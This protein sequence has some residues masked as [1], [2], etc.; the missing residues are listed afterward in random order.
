[1][2]NIYSNYAGY[3]YA[4][5]QNAYGYPQPQPVNNAPVQPQPSAQ[6]A[7]TGSNGLP[8]V[9]GIEGAYAFPMPAGV[10]QIILWDDTV[11][12]FYIKGYDNMGKPKVLAWNDFHPHVEEQKPSP[13]PAAPQPI[14]VSKFVTKDDL[15]EALSQLSIGESGRIVRVNE[16]DA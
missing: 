6:Q 7:Q 9:H 12:S 13:E 8:Y 5:Y 15:N 16:H 2:P 4:P 14:D 3:P 11:D 1:M 10:N